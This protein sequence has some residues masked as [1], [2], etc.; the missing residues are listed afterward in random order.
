MVVKKNLQL[1]KLYEEKNL[2]AL[3]DIEHVNGLMYGIANYRKR[4][5]LQGIFDKYK[6]NVLIDKDFQP[7]EGYQMQ[8]Y[9][10][11]RM[12]T[13]RYS[14]T[15]PP[16]PRLQGRPALFY[17]FKDADGDTSVHFLSL[18]FYLPKGKALTAENLQII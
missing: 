4:E 10:E 1:K 17:L 8:L 5:S 18:T 9:G 11:S 16:D 15:N 7:L 2:E 6:E 13:L 14:I 12:V 3:I